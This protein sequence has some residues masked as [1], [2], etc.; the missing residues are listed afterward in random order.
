MG[1][2]NLVLFTRKVSKAAGFN[3]SAEGNYQE[4]SWFLRNWCTGFHNKYLELAHCPVGSNMV[5]ENMGS[6]FASA[7]VFES[8]PLQSHWA[9]WST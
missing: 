2:Q 8:N 7:A 3:C 9:R 6:V 4:K 5:I 1:S